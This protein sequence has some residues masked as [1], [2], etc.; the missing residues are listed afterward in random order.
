MDWK[1]VM[2]GSIEE[3]WVRFKNIMNDLVIRYIPRKKPNQKG[4]HFVIYL[5]N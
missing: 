1:M 5:L 3:C 2:Q 4:I